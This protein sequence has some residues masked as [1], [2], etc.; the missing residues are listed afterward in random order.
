MT[1]KK[2][3]KIRTHISRFAH[4]INKLHT[5]NG[6]RSKYLFLLIFKYDGHTVLRNRRSGRRR[7]L[8]G[9]GRSSAEDRK[10]TI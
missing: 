7:R 4:R 5:R 8:S 2:K 9:R 6:G 1:R 10:K 3:K